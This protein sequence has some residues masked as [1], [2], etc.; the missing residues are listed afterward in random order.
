MKKHWKKWKWGVLFLALVWLLVGPW[1]TP[2]VFQRPGATPGYARDTFA[3]LG[4]MRPA[5]G[6]GPLLVGAG[7]AE[8]TC[9][10]G[11]P[12]LG[13][14]RDAPESAGVHS[15][16]YATALTLRQGE[17]TATLLTL[18]LFILAPAFTAAVAKESGVPEDELYFTA[19]HTHSG[20]GGWLRGGMLE[21]VYGRAQ[22]QWE[23]RVVGAAA[24][25][26]RASRENLRPAK[27]FCRRAPTPGMLENR[28]YPDERPAREVAEALVF[29]E[30]GGQGEIIAT[31]LAYAA[32]ATLVRPAEKR[33]SADYPGFWRD[34]WERAHGGLA[35][36][37]AG[38]VG[39]ARAANGP[40][41]ENFGAR[42]AAELGRA[43]E[44]PLA[45][46]PL[47]RLWLPVETPTTRIPLGKSW[48][49]APLVAPC[50]LPAGA[51]LCGL[52]VGG[53]AL[54]GWPGDVAGELA[55]PLEEKARAL[56]LRLFITSFNGD[57]RCYFT[58]RET[59]RARAAYE[60]RM[61]FLGENGGDYFA[62]LSA[63][64]LEKLAAE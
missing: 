39:D 49:W 25:A 61:G 51:R 58:T 32:H 64:M 45:G 28:I 13:F 40:T 5:R 47:A 2:E 54:I 29:R 18:D 14:L 23:A 1:P 37:A 38:C 63:K 55:P 33:C 57:W 46:G 44:E 15:R 6:E 24:A 59:Y 41:A 19:S 17:T 30:D 34:A 35:M 9:L 3:R 11:Q 53:A 20:P 26:V 42:L 4:A 56:G 43:A 7:R 62:A 48:R 16:C 10:P 8:M 27:A 21:M 52:R 22:P 31:F 60:V 50:L 36:F 12:R